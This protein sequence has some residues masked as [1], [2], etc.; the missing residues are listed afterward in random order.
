MQLVAGRNLIKNS[1]LANTWFLH[2]QTNG[3]KK[4]DNRFPLEFS[5][6]DSYKN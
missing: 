5:A 4:S 3:E 6:R 1:S 2:K